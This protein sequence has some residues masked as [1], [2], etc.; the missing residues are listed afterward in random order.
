M[1]LATAST[2]AQ[3]SAWLAL[4]VLGV[5]G[6]LLAAAAATSKKDRRK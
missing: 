4:F 6:V 1:D 5:F 2:A 3:V